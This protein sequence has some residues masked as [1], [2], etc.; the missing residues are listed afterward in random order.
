M[1]SPHATYETAYGHI[2]RQPNGDEDP[3]QRWIDVTGKRAGQ[4]YGLAV[5]NDAKYGYS[6]LDSDMRISIVRG[7][8]YA[9]HQ[10][11]KLRADGEYIWQDQ[12]IQSFRMM[13]VPHTGSWQ[14]AHVVRLA[15][16][17]TAPVPV[18]YQ[19]IHKGSRPQSASFLSVDAPNVVMSAMKKAEE[20]NDLIVRCYETDGRAT[21]ASLE[22][23]WLHKKW[24]GDFRP[25]EI[26]TL[27]VPLGGGN[28]RE[29]N[30][31]EE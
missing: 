19:G 2:E 8:V 9:H 3:G 12:G 14:G 1:E 24:S 13:L 7:A 21:S 10:P 30:L 20:G 18:I 26:K 17:F 6:V 16:E 29:V 31:L 22:L 4:D 15:E 27:R 5:I 25:F 11:S 23:E 28:I